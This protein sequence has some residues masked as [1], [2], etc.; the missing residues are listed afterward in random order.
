[1][2]PY[3]TMMGGMSKNP[4]KLNMDATAFKVGSICLGSISDPVGG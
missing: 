4:L 2:E 1:M 3:K